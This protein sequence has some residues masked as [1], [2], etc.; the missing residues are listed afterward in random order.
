MTTLLTFAATALLCFPTDVSATIPNWPAEKGKEFANIKMIDGSGKSVELKSLK[1]S[2][3]VIELIGMTCAGC[4]AFSG[5]NIHG[6]FGKVTPQHNLKSLDEYFPTYAKGIQ[7]SDPRLKFVQIIFFNEN[8]VPP[9]A[10]D[11]SKWARHFKL[12]KMPNAHVFGA[13]KEFIGPHTKALIPGFYLVTKD[14]TLVSDSCGHS[15]KDN[16]YTDLLPKVAKLLE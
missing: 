5:G 13:N 11:V 7:L 3:L 8:L 9:T 14:F 1:G 16:L 10:D 4:Q 12:D 6:G 2:V 15:P